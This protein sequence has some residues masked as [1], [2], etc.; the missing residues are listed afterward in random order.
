MATIK[1]QVKEN[2]N[3]GTHS[4]YSQAVS[5]STLDL[6][7]LSEEIV[8]GMGI[9]PLL[10]STVLNR[11]MQVAQRQVNRGHRV[12]FGNLLTIFPKISASV[13]DELDAEGNVVK[14][15]TLADFTIAGGK[16][17]IEATIN[18]QV[19]QQFAQSVSW[20][21]ITEKDDAPEE[22]TGDTT[23][24]PDSGS[25]SGEGGDDDPNSMEP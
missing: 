10:V 9:S 6:S 2:T 17:T 11:A 7:D 24:D 13:K 3:L 21:R 20:K 4:F 15:A 1:Y 19:N 25:G 23:Q 18:Q 5:Y 16:S 8:E 14:A 22:T 12:R